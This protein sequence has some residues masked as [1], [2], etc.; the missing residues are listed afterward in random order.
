MTGVPRNSSN[1]NA[2]PDV[3]TAWNGGDKAPISGA[4]GCPSALFTEIALIVARSGRPAVHKIFA[5]KITHPMAA[6]TL[7]VDQESE[8]LTRIL[9]RA[10]K[11]YIDDSTSSKRQKR[12]RTAWA[13]KSASLIFLWYR[14]RALLYTRSEIPTFNFTAHQPGRA[15]FEII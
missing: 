13:D 10:L 15:V 3:V 11:I 5:A 1:E 2:A 4:T 14:I 12:I 6:I 8:S 9:S 7:I